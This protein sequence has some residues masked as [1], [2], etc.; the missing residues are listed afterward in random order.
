MIFGWFVCCSWMLWGAFNVNARCSVEFPVLVY[1][2]S[3]LALHVKIIAHLISWWLVF[4]ILYF[5]PMHVL[6]DYKGSLLISW[7]IFFCFCSMTG[8]GRRIIHSCWQVW[9][10]FGWQSE[11][12]WHWRQRVYDCYCTV[13]GVCQLRWCRCSAIF[14]SIIHSCESWVTRTSLKSAFD[15]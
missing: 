14:A 1:W 6:F 13:E 12:Q 7:L 5:L 9:K 4:A 3:C 10:C 8:W 11:R 2:V 15:E